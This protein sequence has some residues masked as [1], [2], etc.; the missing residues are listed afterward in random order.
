MLRSGSICVSFLYN[1]LLTSENTAG[2]E[3]L[4]AKHNK[5]KCLSDTFASYGGVLA[6]LSQILCLDNGKGE[7]FSECKPYCQEETIESFKEEVENNPEFFKNAIIDFNVFKSGSVGQ[8]HKAIYKGDSEDEEI[9]IKVQYVGLHEQFKNDIF[10]LDNVAK[11]LFYFS[12][13]SSAMTDI[14]TKL[15]DELNYN[16]EY[17]NQKKVYDIWKD[18]K[19]ICIP[20]LI[21]EFCT[22]NLLAMRYIEAE[23]LSSFI[24]ESTQEQRNNIAMYIFEFIF[25]NF[26]KHGIFYSDIHYGNFLIKDKSILYVTDFGCIND[27]SQDFLSKILT[28]HRAILHKNEDA[29]Y[30]I[31]KD[32]GILKDDISTESKEYMYEY[33]KLQ[34]IPWTEEDFE[35]TQEWTEKFMYKNPEL[36]KEWI[37][38][39]DCVYLNKIPFG[40]FHLLNKLKAKCNFK[41]F[42][43]DIL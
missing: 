13:L 15:Y 5:L 20:E 27:I 21:P 14:K 18:N 40:L 12:D 28:L 30:E 33:F 11:Y 3:T 25:S 26:Y 32:I 7:V 43:D 17:E 8:V 34:Y 4:R 6:K 41:K 24:A 10:I 16:L 39:N 19:N 22:D 37:L 35:F 38:P 23:N 42:F 2:N 36:M 1:Y 9:I 31:V 29:F